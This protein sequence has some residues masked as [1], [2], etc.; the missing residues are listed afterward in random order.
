MQ[1]ESN[2]LE[3]CDY[4]FIFKCIY[5]QYSYYCNEWIEAQDSLNLK[6][7]Q[8]C[9][10][11]IPTNSVEYQIEEK[12]E[13]YMLGFRDGLDNLYFDVLTEIYNHINLDK[14]AKVMARVKTVESI[15]DKIQRKIKV[16]DGKFSIN[17]YLNDLLGFR[18]IDPYYKDN[19]LGIINLLESYKKQGYTI[20]N[21]KRSNNGYEGYHI[22]FKKGNL[23]F[24]IEIQI[25]DKKNEQKNIQSHRVYKQSYLDSIIGNYNKF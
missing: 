22:Y 2:K 19:I 25:W 10:I 15:I 18:I 17:K 20:I 21:K 3:I 1:T 4:D 11:Y 13:R 7:I 5:K 14:K 8:I 9:D 24:P 12:F 6:K 16:E 23:V